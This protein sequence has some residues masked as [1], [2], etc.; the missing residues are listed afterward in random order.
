M[1]WRSMGETIAAGIVAGLGKRGERKP[2][3]FGKAN[4]DLEKLVFQTADGVT[5]RIRSTSAYLRKVGV[6]AQTVAPGRGR[7][8]WRTIVD[9]AYSRFKNELMPEDNAIDTLHRIEEDE[10][11]APES[12]R[13][14][15]CCASDVG[16]CND[17]FYE[18][19]AAVLSEK[20]PTTAVTAAQR[21]T[22]DESASVYLVELLV[23]T[24]R[25]YT[26]KSREQWR[27]TGDVI[28]DGASFRVPFHGPRCSTTRYSDT[29]STPRSS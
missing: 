26:V 6:Y 8:W 5:K 20:M 19:L 4:F 3:L 23:Q 16:E 15:S 29:S 9:S 18:R 27:R 24:F 28:A 13:A 21:T 25:L 22:E 14:S 7:R 11:S 17:E 10:A 2:K 12:S 1:M